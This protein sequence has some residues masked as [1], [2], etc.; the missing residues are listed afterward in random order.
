MG[1]FGGFPRRVRSLVASLLEYAEQSNPW[2][3][4]TAMILAIVAISAALMAALWNGFSSWLSWDMEPAMVRFA[5]ITAAIVAFVVATP[6]VLFGYFLV[7][8]ILSVK[9]DL[10]RALIAADVANRAK[11]EFLANMSHEIRTPLNGVLGMAQVLEASDLTREQRAALNMIGESG[12]LLMGII[13]DVL[14]LAKIEVGEVSLDPVAQPLVKPLEDIVELFRPRATENGTELQFSVSGDMPEQARF[15]S[16]RV[17]QCLAN[18]V[19]NAVK[20]TS[21]GQ[22]TVVLRATSAGVGWVISATV[23]DNGPGISE[24]VQKR[25]FKPFEQ[26]DAA[27]TRSYG[28]TGLGLAI[29][30][31]LARLMGGDITLTSAPGQGSSFVLTFAVERVTG[32]AQKAVAAHA[33]LAGLGKPLEGRHILV[34]DDSRI[35]RHVVLGLLKPLGPSCLQAENGAV[36]LEILADTAVDLILLDMQMPVLDGPQTLQALRQLDGPISGVPVIALTAN[37]MNGRKADYVARG[38][39]GFLS[40]PLNREDLFAE[41]QAVTGW[42]I[43]AGGPPAMR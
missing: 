12:E 4:N 42:K 1:T 17:R 19:S 9:S 21:G 40:K 13:A 22:I 10:R 35:N 25:L 16:V 6:A 11:T 8:R 18:L 7:E 23:T 14:D 39:Q 33:D 34:V 43:G 28:G 32:G 37:V 41:L 38:F 24:D 31:R 27:T 2:Y 29:S 20:F 26:A 15:D 3:F 5:T 30:R 36:A